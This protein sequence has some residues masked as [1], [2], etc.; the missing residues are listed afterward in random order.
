[1]LMHNL[2]LTRFE[3]EGLDGGLT[4]AD[5]HA[6]H[7]PLPALEQVIEEQPAL[8]HEARKLSARKHLARL[9]AA[10]AKMSGEPAAIDTPYFVAPTASNSI[11]IVVKALSARGMRTSLVTPTFD[12]LALLAR[13]SR[14]DLHA[15]QHEEL[16]AD[17][18]G[19][20]TGLSSGDALFLVDPNNP[21]G[22]SVNSETLDELLA[23]SAWR[24]VS[25]IIDRTFR[26]YGAKAEKDLIGRL[27]RAGTSFVVIEDT[28]KTW[29]TQDRKA[30]QVF[31]SPDWNSSLRSI[32]EEIYLCPSSAD[33]AL[34]TRL[35]E[36]ESELG[37]PASLTELVQQ[38]R[39]RL[40]AVLADSPVSVAPE[41]LSSSL[42]VEW[43]DIS[44]TG[45]VDIDLV[46]RIEART[47]VHVLPGAPFY[48]SNSIDAPRNRVRVSLLRPEAVFDQS[49]QRLSAYF[50]GAI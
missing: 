5:G 3:I 38:R 23:A 48:W 9:V 31:F 30:S 36:L 15:V 45:L 37:F 42:P 22:I 18:V 16:I 29:P 25:L 43:I 11:D 2:P 39:N 28:G 41:S 33:V 32:Y 17:P 14:V 4:L 26:Y 34:F 44:A 50:A 10:W 7:E 1:M 46:K 49:L 27:R 13:R 24:G 8:W 21:T 19:V 20:V 6:S 40:R 47:G 35:F 12:N